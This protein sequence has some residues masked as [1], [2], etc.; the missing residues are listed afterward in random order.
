MTRVA[1]KMVTK[2]TAAEEGAVSGGLAG[3]SV[4]EGVEMAK[5]VVSGV[6]AVAIEV[7]VGDAEVLIAGVEV[8]AIEEVAED[9]VADSG[10]AA[11]DLRAEIRGVAMTETLGAGG[12]ASE[13][14]SETVIGVDGEAVSAGAGV[15]VIS[16]KENLLA[17]THLLKTK[18]SLSTIDPRIL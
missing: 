15:A 4:S 8:V 13:N 2:S 17:M 7:A 1:K 10:V 6:D 3:V 14:P 5:G 9:E 12:M 18:K 16:G 11:V